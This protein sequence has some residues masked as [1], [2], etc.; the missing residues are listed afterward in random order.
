[1]RTAVFDAPLAAVI[2]TV[3]VLVTVLVDT[4]KVAVVEPG[5]TETLAGTVATAVALLESETDVPPAGAGPDIVTVPVDGEDPL[6][7]VGFRL[8]ALTTGAV[9][10]KLA[11]LVT[12]RVPEI[13]TEV[14]LDTGLVVIVNVAVVAPG[15]T[16]MLAGT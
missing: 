8:R 2:V 16:V 11:V 7:V 4:V 12:P 10:V 13:V 1:M 3:L 6:T 9:T 14:L 15:A 5:A